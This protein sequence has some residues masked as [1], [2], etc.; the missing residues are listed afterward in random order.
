MVKNT[1]PT[2]S[3]YSRSGK[4]S[5]FTLI[6]LLV[7]IAIIAI[8]AAILFPVFAQA[9]EKARAA[10]C[11]SNMRQI[12]LAIAMYRGDYDSVNP[13]HRLCP[14]VA[15]DPTCAGASP[16]VSTGPNETWW[17][18]YDNTIS[19][20]P[21]NVS[22]LTYTTTQTQGMLFGYFKSF[23]IFKCPDYPQGQIG[24]AMSYITVGPKGRPDSDIQNPTC[25]VVWDHSKTPG[26]ADTRTLPHPATQPW[27][28]FPW[29]PASAT[30][31]STSWDS[32]HTHYPV[33]HTGGFLGLCYDGHVK[34]RNPLSLT[35]TDFDGVDSP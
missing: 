14:D 25:Y 2:P 18:P 31:A 28:P 9:R 5:A 19:S 27:L 1:C 16:I 22:T 21:A 7:V 3:P 29:A 32:G 12:G 8:L 6:E 26:C 17:A 20:E 33:R 13:Y 24:Y 35:N 34:W 15:T 11:T 30:A 4:C 10:S 23:G